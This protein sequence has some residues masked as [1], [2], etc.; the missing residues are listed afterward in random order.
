M[1]KQLLDEV[2]Y[3]LSDD[4][5]TYH[6]FKDKYCMF[7]LDHYIK[8]ETPVK[9]I[10]NSHLARFCQKPV[11]KTWLAGMGKKTVNPEMIAAMWPTDLYHFTVTLGQWGGDDPYWQQ[12]AR[13][14]F[15]LV[16]QLNFSRTHDRM[17]QAVIEKD[18]TYQPFVCESHP[19]HG[20]RNTIAWARLD[21]SEDFSEVLIEEV[22]NDWLR[23][24][25]G[26]YQSIKKD[27]NAERLARHGFRTNW[28][29]LQAYF[30]DEIKPM[31]QVWDEAILCATLEYVVTQI[32]AEK[33]YMYD[34]LTGVEMKS[35][36]HWHPPRS[37]YTQLPKKFGFEITTESPRFYQDDFRLERRMKKIRQR[38]TPKWHF[39]NLN[40]GGIYAQ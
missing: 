2:L 23:Y 7:L 14:G 24:A 22:Q 30:E 27:P 34:H 9:N 5:H 26:L 11:V 16:V 36:G 35:M 6:Y 13:P 10:K 32:G 4:R 17:Y 25:W 39:L 33:I 19:I 28:D 29:R 15:N 1:N 38:M 18:S 40:K 20:H 31:M 12:T 8:E 3:C 37:L 21:I